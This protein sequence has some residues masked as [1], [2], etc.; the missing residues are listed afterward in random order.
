MPTSREQIQRKLG[1][2]MLDEIDMLLRRHAEEKAKLLQ[3]PARIEEIDAEVSVL[4]EE[5]ARL[6]ARGQGRSPENESRLEAVE[7]RDRMHP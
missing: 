2:K 1:Q 6:I 7:L 4:E 3:A 5:R